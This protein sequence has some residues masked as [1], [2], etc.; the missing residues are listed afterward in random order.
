VDASQEL[1]L[2]LGASGGRDGLHG[3]HG[4]IPP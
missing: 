3:L 1:V 4:V 2:A